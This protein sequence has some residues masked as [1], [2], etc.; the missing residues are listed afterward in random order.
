MTWFKQMF[1]R[2]RRYVELA[3][4]I[5]EH[6]D[7]KIADLMDRGMT[8]EEAE[9]T[10]RR[11]FG[12]VTLIE[13]RSREVWQWL[14]LESIWAD[15]RFAFR[16]INKSPGFVFAACLTLALG[17]GA[18]TA[19]FSVVNA[20]LLKNLPYVQ[21]HR[22]GT[23]YARITGSQ[24]SDERRTI[25]GEQWELLRDNVPSVLS[26]VSAI[27]PAGVVLQTGSHAQ[28]L[29]S[30][31]VS[32]HYF[33]VLGIQ[34]MLGQSFTAEEDLPNG[35]RVAILSYALWRT[36]FDKDPHVLGQVILL[37]G[38]PYTVI[39]VLPERATTPLDADIYTDLQPSREGEGQAT[40][41]LA[42]VLL[43]NGATWQEA[44]GQI[45][46]ALSQSHQALEFAKNNP[47]GRRTYYWMPLQQAETQTLRPQVL[48]L[49]LASGLVLLIACANLAGLALVRMLRRTGEI[50]TRMALGAS[51]WRIQR[52]L[53][54]ENLLVALIGGSAGIGLGYL[55]LRSLLKML[56]EHFL[57][58]QHVSL[59]GR[60]LAF[61]LLLSL[62]TSILFGMLPAFATNKVNLRSSMGSRAVIGIGGIRL[63]QGMIAG[64][65]AL[66]VLLLA[67]AGLL[68]RTL[69]HLETMSPG[70]NPRG[71]ITAQASLDNV[72][73]QTPEA[74]QTMFRESLAA[75][76]NIPGVES[77]AV[78]LTLPYERALLDGVTL[79]DGKQAGEQVTTNEVFVTPGYF[80]TLQI[81]LLAGRVFTDTDGQHMQH[82]VIVNETFA[83]KFF[84]EANSVGRQLQNNNNNAV[85]V[86]VVADTVLSSE[87]HLVAGAAPLANQ[88]TIYVPY[89]QVDDAKLLS[90][91]HTW[92]QPSWIVRAAHPGE[93]L[94]A[95]MQRALASVDPGLPFSGFYSMS[96]LEAKT[97][98]M[99]RVEVALLTTMAALALLLSAVGI[100]ALV[101]HMVAERSREIGIRLALGSTIQQ[102]MIYVGK[103]GASASVAGL[104]LGLLACAGV[105]RVLHSILYG[106]QV[107][108]APTLISVVVMVGAVTAL[109]SAIPAL[110]IAK[111]DPIK[112]L[113]E[114]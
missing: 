98:A 61:T 55:A 78:G 92:I 12:N 34:P 8:R 108:D 82:V 45:E 40:N 16:Q 75:M 80:K 114:Q 60:V 17:I 65:V 112:A 96:D 59:D 24:P 103:S 86:G 44:N 11:E 33:D 30:G 42:T 49:M 73:Y 10:A 46:R 94:T 100:F 93:D 77:A 35:P 4:T 41:F 23:L 88:E 56:P 63:R 38:E 68:I 90:M 3:E 83:R 105:L 104:I 14:T 47:D 7:E 1:S 85:V 67:A 18:N 111:I 52:Q 22:I 79:S 109:A 110:R 39:G 102:A 57:P 26:T 48:A 53:W 31:R 36:A 50:A 51:R 13:Q 84:H 21:P 89:V 27:H 37:K 25:D 87:T 76:R 72:R 43:R 81:P 32:A 107:Y 66:T 29:H 15:I 6:L 97:L 5:R 69:V 64:E 113:R 58:V 20:L 70:F 95:Q 71:V 54:I 28:Y 106:V 62:L 9:R 101:A 2:R 74:L 99:Q 91:V 19:I